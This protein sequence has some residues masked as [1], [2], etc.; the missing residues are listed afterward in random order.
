MHP[1]EAAHWAYLFE[2]GPGQ[3]KY[4]AALYPGKGNIDRLARD[5]N[6]QF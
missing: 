5:A 1:M 2:S 3:K 6:T 4:E